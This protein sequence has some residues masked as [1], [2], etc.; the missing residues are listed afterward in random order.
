MLAFVKRLDFSPSH[1]LFSFKGG[2]L[3]P[4]FCGA[5]AMAFMLT[6]PPASGV[7][8]SWLEDSLI[9]AIIGY[10]AALYAVE[11]IDPDKT[12]RWARGVAFCSGI[13]VGITPLMLIPFFF[14]WVVMALDNIASFFQPFLNM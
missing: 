11:L 12:S 7:H 14:Y 3:S 8:L 9:S 5:I 6:V 1:I 2:I 4:F 10:L 13:T